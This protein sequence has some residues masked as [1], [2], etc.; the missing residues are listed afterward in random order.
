MRTRTPTRSSSALICWVARSLQAV[1]A[2]HVVARRRCGT[3]PGV[4]GREVLEN[5][6]EMGFSGRLIAVCLVTYGSRASGT[7]QIAEW[8][9]DELQQ[10]GHIC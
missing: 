8:I 2:P 6:R 5:I 4:I 10:A 7:A 1:L 3:Q 9:V